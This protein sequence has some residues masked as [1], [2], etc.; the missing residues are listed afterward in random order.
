MIF[1]F[2]I[3][4][5]NIPTMTFHS[6]PFH[7]PPN[8]SLSVLFF[9]YEAFYFSQVLFSDLRRHF[10]IHPPINVLFGFCFPH[11]HACVEKMTVK[12]T[13]VSTA[14]P[15]HGSSSF[16]FRNQCVCDIRLTKIVFNGTPLGMK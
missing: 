15:D 6:I 5:C 8:F 12:C 2:F 1:L 9:L 13:I 11:R 7:S 4:H 3:L 16:E 14:C 10:V